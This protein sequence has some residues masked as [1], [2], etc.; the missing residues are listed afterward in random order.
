MVQ[1]SKQ[2]ESDRKI[3]F[4]VDVNEICF[5]QIINKTSQRKKYQTEVAST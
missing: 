5:Q 2:M 1:K 4:D 3:R